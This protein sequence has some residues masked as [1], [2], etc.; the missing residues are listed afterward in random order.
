MWNHQLGLAVLSAL[1]YISRSSVVFSPFVAPALEDSWE[2]FSDR[3][4]LPWGLQRRQNGCPSNYSPC[5]AALGVCCGAGTE[6]QLDQAGHV[7]C[8][9]QG[10]SCTGTISVGTASV[11]SGSSGG[12][13]L[14]GGSTSTSTASSPSL[15]SAATNGFIVP[16]ATTTTT[17]SVVVSQQGFTAAPSNT[18][19][20]ASN[21]V[22]FA[23]VPTSFSNQQSCS[24]AYS[25]CQT[26]YSKCTASLSGAT[27]GVTIT[28]VGAGAGVTI[29]GPSVTAAPV[30]VSICQ[31]LSSQACLSLQLSNCNTFKAGSNAAPT[32]WPGVYGVGVGVGLALGVAEQFLG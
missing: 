23:P 27:N 24:S 1:V 5:S 11:S 14:G 31:S 28:G 16:A 26:E 18:G 15:S 29:G 9:P 6:C 21:Y 30:A 17:S 8:C 19:G 25:S 20:A 13:V 10:S 22:G 7:A 2:S 4:G 3:Q 12:F 32:A